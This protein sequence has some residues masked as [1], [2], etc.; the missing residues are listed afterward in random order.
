MLSTAE[1]PGMRAAARSSASVLTPK[2]IETKEQP[3][4]FVK[5][6]G[7]RTADKCASLQ[8]Q[9]IYNL[10]GWPTP[11]GGA[12]CALAAL[13]ASSTRAPDCDIRMTPV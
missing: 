4:T 7:D 2:A 5:R 11:V 12:L 1:A 9:A 8:A 6:M 3:E 13:L 10:A